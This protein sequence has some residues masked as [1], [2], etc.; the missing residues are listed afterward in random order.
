LHAACLFEP[1][2]L[3]GLGGQVGRGLAL[4]RVGGAAGQCGLLVSARTMAKAA[5][6]INRLGA[7]KMGLKK[8]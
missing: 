5:W 3:G 6:R 1:S 4:L 7:T 8:V 2:G